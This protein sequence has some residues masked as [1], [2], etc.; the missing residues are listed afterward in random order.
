MTSGT[1]PAWL[2]EVQKA[3]RSIPASATRPAPLLFDRHHQ[4]ITTAEGW[5]RHRAALRDD[6]LRFLGTIPRPSSPPGFT[7]LE[8]DRSDIIRQLIRYEAE[9][10][11]PVEAYL[12]RPKGE[13]KSAPGAVVLHS[14][15]DI[16]IRQPAGLEG[17]ES[18]HIG[19]QLAQRG[20][21]V[22]CPRCFLWQYSRPGKIAEA[23][24][25]LR[26]RHPSVR[27]MAK[28]L[29]DAVRAVDLLVSLPGVDARRVGAIGHSLGAKEVL[30]LAAFDERIRATV[31]SE[32]GIGLG[33]SNWDA[34]WYLG[35]AIHRPGFSLDH[36]QV[37]AL[38]AP[39]AF[40]LLGGDSADGDQSWPYI[41]A[42]LP[43]WRLTG[44]PEA[45][46]LFNHRQGHAFP[47]IARD[48]SYE[49][50]DWFLR[51]RE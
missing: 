26:D 38:A 48:R 18:H 4:P 13:V 11:L 10:G 42:A 36:G 31:S 50:L 27:G 23:V 25:W 43:V 40:L 19:K 1:A 49:W 24:D 34:P 51:P 33:Y 7:V 46:G 16:T 20:Y 37:L 47:P 17:P 22:V 41:E 9:P 29:F 2:A 30:Y 44:A 15:A 28:M 14:T 12:L 3:P 5:G 45:V 35:D 21:V 39:R 6:W 32:G 8:E